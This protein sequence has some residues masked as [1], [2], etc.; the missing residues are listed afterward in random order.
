EKRDMLTTFLT[1]PGDSYGYAMADAVQ[2]LLLDE[3]MMLRDREIYQ[4]FGIAGKD[5]PPMQ[6]TLGSRV[7]SFLMATVRQQL[8]KSSRRLKSRQALEAL[9][10]KG[11]L[12]LF[13]QHP[14]ASMFGEQTGRN[15]GGLLYSRSPTR[16]WHEAVGQLRDIDMKGCYNQITA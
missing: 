6:K 15:H 7:A 14:E 5:V 4:R 11:S 8:G 13:R 2:T 1:R 10:R 3:Q 9:M 16:F 12:A